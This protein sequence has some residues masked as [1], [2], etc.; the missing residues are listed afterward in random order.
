MFHSYTTHSC[1]ISLKSINAR[2]Q[3]IA[4]LVS[5]YCGA[6]CWS[7]SLSQLLRK[8]AAECFFWVKFKPETLRGATNV[9]QK[10]I[11]LATT[12]EREFLCFVA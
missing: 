10:T 5:P 8:L 11:E 1:S 9:I 7:G 6:G 2:N 3:K 12:G 4:K